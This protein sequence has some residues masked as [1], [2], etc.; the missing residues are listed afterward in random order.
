MSLVISGASTI[1]LVNKRSSIEIGK[2]NPAKILV[3]TA[4]SRM[5]GIT[6]EAW[7]EV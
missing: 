1:K 6:A 2:S 3:N 4:V 5:S 7:K